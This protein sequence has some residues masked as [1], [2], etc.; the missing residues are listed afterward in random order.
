MRY[1]TA[2]LAALVICGATL[3]VSF[4]AYNERLEG[5]ASSGSSE[6]RLVPFRTAVAQRLWGRAPSEKELRADNNPAG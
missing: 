5:V 6:I 4:I 1:I 3:V 2:G